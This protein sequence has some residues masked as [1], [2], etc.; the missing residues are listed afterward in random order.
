MLHSQS[1]LK[2]KGNSLG[3]TIGLKGVNGKS[4]KELRRLFSQMTFFTFTLIT[5]HN[6]LYSVRGERKDSNF[7]RA[8]LTALGGSPF[9][10]TQKTRG[11]VP[12][13]AHAACVIL[14]DCFEHF[15]SA[16][17][18]SIRTL[19][20]HATFLS[21]PR[22]VVIR[23]VKTPCKRFSA[24]E[25]ACSM[26]TN[27]HCCSPAAYVYTGIEP[28]LPAWLESLKIST[29]SS[30]N[31]RVDRKAAPGSEDCLGKIK[32]DERGTEARSRGRNLRGCLVGLDGWG[33]RYIYARVCVSLLLP[34]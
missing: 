32:R 18:T 23:V 26:R 6:L 14:I 28:V 33:A 27:W 1:V 34:R 13:R 20:M 4:E 30:A 22:A 19:A 3:P 24:I 10:L 29:G 8:D 21:R 9:T 25:N 7:W 16:G 5:G 2:S 12:C 15:S 11:F 17:S 31:G